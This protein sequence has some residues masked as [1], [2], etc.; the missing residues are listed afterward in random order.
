MIPLFLKTCTS[1]YANARVAK[2]T[3][4]HTDRGAGDTVFCLKLKKLIFEMEGNGIVNSGLTI[5]S[6]LI[7]E[8]CTTL[9]RNLV[10]AI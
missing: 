3:A 5:H 10:S 8:L 6:S 4:V 9:S 2:L 1:F 7:Q